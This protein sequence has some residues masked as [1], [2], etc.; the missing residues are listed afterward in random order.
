MLIVQAKCLPPPPRYRHS[1]C[2]MR[3]VEW[4]PDS[5]L[6][7]HLHMIAQAADLAASPDRM[8]SQFSVPT[9]PW[10]DITPYLIH[11][12]RLF[13]DGRV[14]RR[15]PSPPWRRNVRLECE[16]SQCPMSC[17][18]RHVQAREHEASLREASSCRRQP[19][20]FCPPQGFARLAAEPVGLGRIT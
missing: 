1:P 13:P 20:T 10:H 5:A 12:L 7:A 18:L 4:R 19:E 15:S 9:V 2:D 14:R 11:E 3:A 16:F 6:K 8:Q 17:V